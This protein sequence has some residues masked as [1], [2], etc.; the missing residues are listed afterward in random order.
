MHDLEDLLQALQ[1]TMV[2]GEYVFLTLADG[3]YGDGGELQPIASFIEAEGLTLVVSKQRADDAGMA[4]DGVFRLLTLAVHSSLQAVGLTA[5]VSGRLASHGISVN[6]IAA[7]HHDHLFV[8][9]SQADRAL[10][11]LRCLA[12]DSSGKE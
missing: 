8:P 4:Y 10:E 2:A 5:A 11:L 6:V 3:V 1:P 7:F 9:E 12:G